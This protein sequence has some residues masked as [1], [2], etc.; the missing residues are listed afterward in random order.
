M[1]NARS[2]YIALWFYV[3]VLCILCKELL[4]VEIAMLSLAIYS[5]RKCSVRIK[6]WTK[7]VCCCIWHGNKHF[8]GNECDLILTPFLV[9]FSFCHYFTFFESFRSVIFFGADR[10]CAE[11]SD[12]SQHVLGA[13]SPIMLFDSMRNTRQ[14]CL[15]ELFTF[16]FLLQNKWRK[17]CYRTHPHTHNVQNS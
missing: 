16:L 11:H 10:I 4:F 14:K 6:N 3:F 7:F 5:L 8:I 13:S 15:A 1:L 2:F 12:F 9:S 17:H